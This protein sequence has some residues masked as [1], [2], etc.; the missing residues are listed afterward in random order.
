M[1]PRAK[2]L[3]EFFNQLWTVGLWLLVFLLLACWVGLIMKLPVLPQVADAPEPTPL[4]AT[5]E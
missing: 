5:L 2:A 1:N 4:A 3:D